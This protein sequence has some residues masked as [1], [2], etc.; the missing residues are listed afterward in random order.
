MVTAS[1]ESSAADGR[2]DTDASCD[3]GCDTHNTGTAA[4]PSSTE[5]FA[6]SSAANGRTNTDASCDVCCDA[7]TTGAAA[8]P[9]EQ[10]QYAKPP[11][12]AVQE[13]WD[14]LADGGD[15]LIELC[16]EILTLKRIAPL[17]DHPPAMDSTIKERMNEF[18][19]LVMQLCE[20]EH[21]L[22]ET[23]RSSATRP[24]SFKYPFKF[25]LWG[26]FANAVSSPAT[27]ILWLQPESPAAA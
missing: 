2:A 10:Q 27:P 8:I 15:L 12:E 24:S 19:N 26:Y 1:A 3:V 4:I 25:L 18:H 20:I 21:R 5:N 22:E 9:S 6:E 23:Y 11:G 17:D 14:D 13:L 7:H 16:C